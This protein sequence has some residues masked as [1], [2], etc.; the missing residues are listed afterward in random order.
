MKT[1][2][3]LRQEAVVGEVARDRHR[4]DP[5]VA[6]PAQR[7]AERL[8][9]RPVGDVRVTRDPEAKQWRRFLHLHRSIPYH[10][11]A[12]QAL[13]LEQISQVRRVRRAL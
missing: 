6:E 9:R 7:A 11:A 3:E 2:R 10:P 4:V 5:L 12:M 13:F 1:K 8:R